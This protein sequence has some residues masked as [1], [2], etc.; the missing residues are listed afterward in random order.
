[1]PV[2]AILFLSW[3]CLSAQPSVVGKKKLPS[4]L[5]LILFEASRNTGLA[6]ILT[7][8]KRWRRSQASCIFSPILGL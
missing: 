1:M 3:L 2:V 4:P 8:I 7:A 5:Q 6:P